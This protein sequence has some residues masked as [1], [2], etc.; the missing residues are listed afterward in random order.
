[1]ELLTSRRGHRAE[2]LAEIH[3]YPALKE[4]VLVNFDSMTVDR[5]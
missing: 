4:L 1:M 3:D 2:S 5:V